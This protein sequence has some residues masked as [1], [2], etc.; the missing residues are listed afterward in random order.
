M[1]DDLQVLDW[2][3]LKALGVPYERTH[4]RRMMKAGQ[5]PQS[6]ALGTGRRCKVVWYV[7]EVHIW[8]LERASHRQTPRSS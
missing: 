5:F 3:G 8:L 7:S 1:Q 2:K 4:I 6:F